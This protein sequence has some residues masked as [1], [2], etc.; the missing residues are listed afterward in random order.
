MSVTINDVAE[1]A[2]VS[3]KT[4]SRVINREDSVTKETSKKVL[5]AIDELGYVPNLWAKRLRS[6][7]SGMIALLFYDATPAYLMDVI[8]GLMD[9]GDHYHYTINLHRIN[10]EDPKQ[11]D[12]VLTVAEQKQV[13]GFI[14]TSPCDNSNKLINRLHAINFPFV[15]LTPRKRTPENAWVAATDELGSYEAARYL[16]ALG[17]RR[18]GFIQ[19]N[20]EHQASWDR[21]NGFKLAMKEAGIEIDNQF[22]RQG[23][24]TF[25][26]GLREAR[27][28]L[29]MPTPPSAIMAGNDQAAAGVFQAAWELGVTCPEQ[30]SVVG[31]DDV[32]LAR[33]LTPPLTTIKQHIF[34]I[35]K[36]AMSVLVEQLIPGTDEEISIQIPT[37]LIIRNST[38]K[39]NHV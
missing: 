24:W 7:H 2:G 3:M 34:E 11:V 28:L 17:H 4:V 18:I 25:S 8:N 19:G 16:L 23:S 33:Q 35:A 10:V 9:C 13:E 38:A 39:Y 14:I 5:E 30:L 22:I 32:P 29:A 37:E 20:V 31:F 12:R 1:K 36:K 6:G 21:L 26:S 15:E 27:S